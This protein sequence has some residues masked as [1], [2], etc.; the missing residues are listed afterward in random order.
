[1]FI[2]LIQEKIKEGGS[3]IF[4]QASGKESLGYYTSLLDDIGA[5]SINTLIRRAMPTTYPL[6]F[7]MKV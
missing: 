4:F 7:S 3:F 1:M 2:E 5:L 6:E